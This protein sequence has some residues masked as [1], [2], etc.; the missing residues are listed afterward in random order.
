VTSGPCLF[1]RSV[2]G[3]RLPHAAIPGRDTMR[4]IPGIIQERGSG[5]LHGQIGDSTDRPAVLLTKI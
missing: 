1:C 4:R 2:V 3:G 5:V